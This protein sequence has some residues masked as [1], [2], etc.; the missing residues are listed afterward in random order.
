MERNNVVQP[1]KS[2]NSQS[3]TYTAFDSERSIVGRVWHWLWPATPFLILWLSALLWQNFA[4]G[5]YVIFLDPMYE[6]FYPWAI[7]FAAIVYGI[8]FVLWRPQNGRKIARSANPQ[9][10]KPA[11]KSD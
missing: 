4:Q 2:T 5:I 8:R 11:Q 3:V 6:T 10:E 9:T 7:I 1:Q